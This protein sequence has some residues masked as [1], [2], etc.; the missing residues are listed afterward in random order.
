[1]YKHGFLVQID[2]KNRTDKQTLHKKLRVGNKNRKEME[3]SNGVDKQ[4]EMVR[5]DAR[6]NP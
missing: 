5:E 1:M 2:N 4:A 6:R 3:L